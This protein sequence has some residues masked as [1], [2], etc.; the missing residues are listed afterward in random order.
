MRSNSWYFR[1]YTA[2][3][4]A[5]DICFAAVFLL[6]KVLTA[7][8]DCCKDSKIVTNVMPEVTADI[9]PKKWYFSII[10]SGSRQRG[11]EERL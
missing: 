6:Q 7:V 1:C 8:F 10:E 3:K 2:V 4:Q 5:M 11:Y 9:F